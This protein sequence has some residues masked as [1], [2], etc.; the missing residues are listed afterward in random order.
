MRRGD[1]AL[2]G[3]ARPLRPDEGRLLGGVCAAIADRYD[4]DVTLVRL[5]FFVL[6]FARGLGLFVYL[7]LWLALPTRDGRGA[8]VVETAKENV[9]SARAE[10]SGAGDGL[11]AAWERAGDSEWPRPLGRRWLALGLIAAGACILLWSFGAFGWLTVSRGLG[12]TAVLAGAAA[13][14][15]LTQDRG[16]R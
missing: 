11:R 15:S 14:F 7:V 6:I 13:L 5:A 16:H 1:D 8:T 3:P 4:V 9:L 2:S 10:L 12:L